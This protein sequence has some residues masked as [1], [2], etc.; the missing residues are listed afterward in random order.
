MLATHNNCNLINFTN[1]NTTL[2]EV[3]RIK[4]M[5]VDVISKNTT[6]LVDKVNME[7][8]AQQI[9]IQWDNMLNVHL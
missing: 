8:S 6:S 4:K 9:N 7:Q 5:V 2:E 3:E 1:K